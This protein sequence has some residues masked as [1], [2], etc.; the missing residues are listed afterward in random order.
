MIEAKFVR[1]E[2]ANYH[3][4]AGESLRIDGDQNAE[5]TAAE[6]DEK[7]ALD[8]QALARGGYVYVPI[9]SAS[10]RIMILNA[11]GHGALYF[12]GAPHTA[13][14]YGY[15]YYHVPVRVNAGKN[16]LLIRS[17]RGSIR[18]TLSAP[19]AKA[20]LLDGDQT[21]PD[22]IVGAAAD[23]WG[24]VIVDQRL[25]GRDGGPFACQ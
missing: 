13:N 24:A 9:D 22:L 15:D 5:W 25:R 7:G 10:E 18:A 14:I 20:F 16:Q 4:D 1:G 19:P 3:P 2:L 17:G 21:L 23:T 6:F 12:N 8:R 11:S